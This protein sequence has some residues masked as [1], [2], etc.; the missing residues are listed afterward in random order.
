MTPKPQRQLQQIPALQ[1]QDTRAKVVFGGVQLNCKDNFLLPDEADA[2]R[3]WLIQVT[4]T[5]CVHKP[6]HVGHGKKVCKLCKEV[7]S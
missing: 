4:S 1:F 7:V 5:V 6:V 3:D 2:L